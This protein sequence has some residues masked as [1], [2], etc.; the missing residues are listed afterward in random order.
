M[1]HG[2]DVVRFTARVWPLPLN[3]KP[4]APRLAAMVVVRT[5]NG[6]VTT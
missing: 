6:F 2:D 1:T 3:P 5:K 4:G